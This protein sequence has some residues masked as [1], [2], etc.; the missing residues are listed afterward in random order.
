MATVTGICSVALTC[1]AS[2]VQS[3]LIVCSYSIILTKHDRDIN[4]VTHFVCFVSLSVRS[5]RYMK[6]RHDKIKKLVD[7][8]IY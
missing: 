2:P 4:S 8:D 5:N 3:E 6:N 1:H 7:E